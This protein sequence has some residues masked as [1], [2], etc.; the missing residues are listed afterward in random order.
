V[1]PGKATDMTDTKSSSPAHA[2]PGP[3]PAGESYRRLPQGARPEER[4]PPGESDPLTDAYRKLYR[5]IDQARTPADWWECMV[6]MQNIRYHEQY[7]RRK[8]R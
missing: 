8:S 7:A 3:S 4:T 5:R 1:P 6:A 2:A